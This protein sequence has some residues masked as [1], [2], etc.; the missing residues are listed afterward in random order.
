MKLSD[1][2]KHLNAELCGSNDVDI[3]GVSGLSDADSGDISFLAN[4]KYQHLLQTTKASAVLVPN[5][6][7][8]EVGCTLLKVDDPDKAF[9]EAALLFY[10]KPSEPKNITLFLLSNILHN[11]INMYPL[12][13]F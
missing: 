7:N 8:Y 10:Q 2:A 12:L 3:H 1:L 4:Q 9:A 6:F 5:N 13:K 11:I